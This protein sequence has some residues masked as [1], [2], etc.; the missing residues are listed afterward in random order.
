MNEKH[1]SARR[2]ELLA[3]VA[4]HTATRLIEKHGL[5]VEQAADIGNDLAD[6]MADYFG[7]QAVYFV[8]DAGVQL[9][10]RDHQ[11]FMRMRRGNAHELAAE[12][13]ISYVRVYQI[14]R[15][16]LEQARKH[17]QPDLL[18]GFDDQVA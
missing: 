5:T 14:Y 15:R 17:R 1:S 2:H 7:G 13:G 3:G 10:E 4:E 6:W 11:I 9:D 12:F 8:K 16:R 18:A